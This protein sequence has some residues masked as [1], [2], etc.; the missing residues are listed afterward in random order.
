MKVGGMVNHQSFMFGLWIASIIRFQ[1]KQETLVFLSS[2]A[3]LLWH[4]WKHRSG[5]VFQ[6]LPLNR[7]V[8][9]LV[10]RRPVTNGV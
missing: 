8:Q 6:Q 7:M 2:V 4:I 1:P 10:H 3:I 5:Y 9:E